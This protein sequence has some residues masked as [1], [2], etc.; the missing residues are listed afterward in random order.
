MFQKITL[1]GFSALVTARVS[2]NPDIVY[3]EIAGAEA[4]VKAIWARL[5]SGKTKKSG[6]A[7]GVRIGSEAVYLTRN[8]KYVALRGMSP[9]GQYFCGLLH[10]GATVLASTSRFYLVVPASHA[11]P[12]AAFFPRL[13]Q[14]LAIPLKKEWAAWLWEAGKVAGEYA[15]STPIS[16]LK[17]E[18]HMV[19]YAIT[20][21]NTA[22]WLK[23]I[24]EHLGFET[25]ELCREPCR[26]LVKH[27]E[28][29]GYRLIRR[30]VVKMICPECA[31]EKEE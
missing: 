2:D 11:E 8:T 16:K 14:C 23:L 30:D 6:W 24:R 7:D 26:E 3:L 20:T 17:G 19:G 4:A 28:N 10:P 27:V 9:N 25:C 29:R 1:K 12:P 22:K 13:A 18:G 5:V 31:A 15:Q 21:S